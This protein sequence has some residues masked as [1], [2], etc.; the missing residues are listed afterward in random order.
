MKF[1]AVFVAIVAVA[2]GIPTWNV[3][4]LSNALQN[5]NIDPALVP[6]LQATLNTIMEQLLAGIQIVGPFIQRLT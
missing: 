4:Q 6:Y 5:P 3:E 2:A 1:V